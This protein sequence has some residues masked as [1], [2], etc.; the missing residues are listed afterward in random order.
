MVRTDT[1]AAAQAVT[2]E[3]KMPSWE[4]QREL[5]LQ[6][7]RYDWK[8]EVLQNVTMNGFMDQATRLPSWLALCEEA[9][10]KGLGSAAHSPWSLSPVAEALG[11]QLGLPEVLVGI[12]TDYLRSEGLPLTVSVCEHV[13]HEVAGDATAVSWEEVPWLLTSYRVA[14]ELPGWSASDD[15]LLAELYQS[16]PDMNAYGWSGL[17]RS[18]F[19][20]L[21]RILDE[22]TRPRAGTTQEW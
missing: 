11:E 10:G 14:T 7:F 15:R 22:L 12:V 6:R 1:P 18:T 4:R 2:L 19:M 5:E 17:R 16:T 21:L 13:W 8:R 20:R 9:G 3:Q